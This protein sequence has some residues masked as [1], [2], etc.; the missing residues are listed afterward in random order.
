MA[1]GL[2]ASPEVHAVTIDQVLLTPAEVAACKITEKGRPARREAEVF[3]DHGVYGTLL[4]LVINRRGQG[5]ECGRDKGMVYYF[6][7]S[8]VPQREKAELA[9]RETLWKGDTQATPKR[10][11][12][13]FNWD[14]FLIVMSFKEVQKDVLAAL[15]KKLKH[16]QGSSTVSQGS[17]PSSST[18]SPGTP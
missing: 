7:Y 10:P 17:T 9:A 14:R 1:A 2:C 15:I 3:Y 8:D 6:E 13:I 11:E 12:L 4:P 5:F 16:F 18:V